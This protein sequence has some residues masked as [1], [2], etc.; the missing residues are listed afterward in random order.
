VP[1]NRAHGVIVL[2]GTSAP[3]ATTSRL[4]VLSSTSWSHMAGSTK[5]RSSGSAVTASPSGS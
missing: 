1:F 2:A 4:S 3:R 5:A